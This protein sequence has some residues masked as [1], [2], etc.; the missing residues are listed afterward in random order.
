MS[1]NDEVKVGSKVV[2]LGKRKGTVRFIGTT[3]F[4]PVRPDTPYPAP[5]RSPHPPTPALAV[6]TRPQGCPAVPPNPR[7]L[8]FRTPPP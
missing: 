2:I 1:N 7:A 6:D 5:A 4:G 8:L 3:A